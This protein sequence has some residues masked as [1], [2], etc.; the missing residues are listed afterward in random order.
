LLSAVGCNNP[1]LSFGDEWDGPKGQWVETWRDDFDGPL[2]AAPDP[3]RWNI[4][5]R[6]TGQNQE[7]DYDTDR[8]KNSF[9]DGNGN[10]VL[11]AHQEHF[12]DGSGRPSSQPYTSA[13]LNTR[14][15]LEQAYGKFEARIR[16]PSGKGIWP[17]FWLL[18][19]NIDDVG[20]P[21]CGEIDILEMAGSEPFRVDAS[22]HGPGYSGI[23]ALTRSHDLA[24]GQKF[25]DAFHTFTL[26]WTAKGMRW[27]VDGEVF[28]VRTPQGLAEF[29]RDWVFDHPFYVIINLAVGGLY[30]GSPDASTRFPAQMAIDYI[31]VSRLEPG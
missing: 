15:H 27:L 11:Q 26:E 8:R 23:E 19:S 14:G 13:R 29:E 2:E 30:D 28:H 17:A 31:S 1:P 24:D 6:P 21:R 18:G 16:L 7:Q 4:E 20:W 5:V 25:A 22:L 12:V 3:T 9:L 10:L